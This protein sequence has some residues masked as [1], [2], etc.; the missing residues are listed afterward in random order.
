MNGQ[1]HEDEGAPGNPGVADT[2]ETQQQAGASG[3]LDESAR[4]AGLM[5][6]D[7]L[8]GEE[9]QV[10]DETAAKGGDDEGGANLEK[11]PDPA[12]QKPPRKKQADSSAGKKPESDP[13]KATEESDEKKSKPRRVLKASDLEE[14]TRR[15]AE[16]AAKD[17]LAQAEAERRTKEA[18]DQP[19]PPKE[20]EAPA[21]LTEEADRL[22]MVQKLYPEAYRDRD[23]VKE[24]V[25]GDKKIKDY[26]RQWR[27][28]NPGQRI[29]WTDL[30]HSEF[31]DSTAVDVDAD[32]LSKAE[33]AV[34]REQAVREAEERIEK[35][36]GA[37]LAEVRRIKEESAIAPVRAQ[38]DRV[39]SM[40]LVEAIRPDLLDAYSKDP[41]SVVNEMK[42]DP[43][44]V[45]V[46]Q[47]VES[48]S[49]PALEAAVVYNANPARFTVDSPEVVQLAHTAKR[50][51]GILWEAKTAD[52]PVTSDGR[53]FTSIAEYTKMSQAQKARHYTVQDERLLVPL[54]IAAAKIEA[55]SLAA[56]EENRLA[57]YAKRRG[58]VKNES[59]SS[60]IA[61]AKKTPAAQQSAPAVKA[62][63]APGPDS[64]PAQ[65]HQSG[66]PDAFWKAAGIPIE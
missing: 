22:R 53:Q 26:E 45:E 4:E 33:R 10:G 18:K 29:D 30:E 36:F 23:L 56:A 55:A 61:P 1:A 60:Q 35:K 59:K 44:A 66:I 48:W 47:K 28:K 8:I 63:P 37:D 3:P 62:A 20:I 41:S 43:V 11:G 34:L 19:A 31:M 42:S 32:H 9:P 54:I 25:D 27:R 58:F 2:T 15:A 39:A 46:I 57:E 7:Q 14:M 24:L 51:E 64:T 49:I 21:E 12:P 38:V 6:L 13:Q 5:M 50:A 16:D 65:Q 17:A 52:R 40:S